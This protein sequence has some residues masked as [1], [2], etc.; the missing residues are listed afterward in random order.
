MKALLVAT[1]SH[2]VDHRGFNNAFLVKCGDPL[3]R[4]YGSSTMESHH[5]EQTVYLLQVP[6]P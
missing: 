2:D 3:A 6:P 4:L 1:I 5:Y